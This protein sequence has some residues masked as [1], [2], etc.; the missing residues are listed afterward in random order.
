M[1]LMTQVKLLLLVLLAVCFLALS[2]ASIGQAVY[3]SIYGTVTDA[4]GALVPN[5]TVTVTDEA[6]GT[7]VTLQSN[8]SG[9][10]KADHLIPDLYDVKGAA[11]GFEGFLQ[12]G[13][14]LFADTS[15]QVEALLNAGAS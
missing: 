4:S 11:T 12:K 15:V 6:K 3:G 7:S 13:I 1:K 9:E 8:D 5:A 10:L 14:Q 2:P